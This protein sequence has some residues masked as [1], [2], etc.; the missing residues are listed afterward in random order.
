MNSDVLS[1]Q[2]AVSGRR[3]L[4]ARWALASLL[5]RLSDSM[6][7]VAFLFVGQ[8][9][10]GS[11]GVGA[12]L[13]GVATLVAGLAGPVRARRAAERGD[14]VGALRRACWSSSAVLLA[15]MALITAQAP[16]WALYAVTAVLG[17][18]RAAVPGGLRAL[19][20]AVVPPRSV[21]RATVLDAVGIEVAFITGPALAG[22][23]ISFTGVLPVLLVMAAAT[24]AAGVLVPTPPED[25]V[26]R[27]GPG[28]PAVAGIRGLLAGALLAG[29]GLGLF[30]SAVPA[31]LDSLGHAASW[32][33]VLLGL[34]AAGSA[35]GGLLLAVVPTVP[36]G[37]RRAAAVLALA[38]GIL[39]IP[40][41]AT[42]P[43]LPL[44][45]FLFLAGLPM[46]PLHAIG[47]RTLQQHVPPAR[48]AEG[49]ALFFAAITVGAGIGQM[50]TGALLAV[51]PPDRLLLAAG[52][53]FGLLGLVL[54][55]RSPPPHRIGE[56]DA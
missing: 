47:A 35:S 37:G 10:A 19:L 5:A 23:V 39:F 11:L 43:L 34:L 49:F 52:A 51:V 42:R 22:L 31:R 40:A 36:S 54:A 38:L 24:A 2:A 21:S 6:S 4:W 1:P 27:A 46:T 41:A 26:P 30:E 29:A 20:L 18:A 8:R 28:V 50:V 16:V 44:A 48:H 15:C 9:A 12:V 45:A 7:L 13:A 32:T 14:L 53:L 33:G 25:A 17:L 56:R 3:P 55:V